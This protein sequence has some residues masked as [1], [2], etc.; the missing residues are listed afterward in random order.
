MKISCNGPFKRFYVQAHSYWAVQE[1]A[2]GSTLYAHCNFVTSLRGKRVRSWDT[3]SFSKLQ[4]S[5]IKKISSKGSLYKFWELEPA[6]LSMCKSSIMRRNLVCRRKTWRGKSGG[7]VWSFQS[8]GR[9][10]LGQTP[11]IRALLSSQKLGLNS[12]AAIINK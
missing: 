7:I 10:S 3:D 4:H 9:N 11:L 5:L 8:P 6:E 1:R 12:L 2:F